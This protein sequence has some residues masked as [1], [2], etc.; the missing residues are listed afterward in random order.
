MISS[1]PIVLK[2]GLYLLY[3]GYGVMVELV[4]DWDTSHQ[5]QL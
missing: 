3:L 4:W 1:E 5:Y 2:L